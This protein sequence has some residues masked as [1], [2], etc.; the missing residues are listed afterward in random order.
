MLVMS[1]LLSH[2]WLPVPCN[3]ADA[4]RAAEH[5]RQLLDLALSLIAAPDGLGRAGLYARTRLFEQQG[6]GRRDLSF[7][8][9]R[10]ELAYA[11]LLGPAVRDEGIRTRA[12]RARRVELLRRFHCNQS[13]HS[14]CPDR[15][16]AYPQR[17]FAY[18]WRQR[19]GVVVA[20]GVARV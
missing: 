14:L 15:R 7:A 2:V 17:S 8:E 6:P 19:G 10:D 20:Q 18:G 13:P 9:S 1:S 16:R 5:G 12:A 11:Y 3:H 4:L